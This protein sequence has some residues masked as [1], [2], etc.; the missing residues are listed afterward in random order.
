[1]KMLSKCQRTGGHNLILK[2]LNKKYLKMK[3]N[4]TAGTDGFTAEFLRGFFCTDF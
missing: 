2:L 1:M 4:K 3:N